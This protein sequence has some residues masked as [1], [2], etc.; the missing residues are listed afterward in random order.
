M[1]FN[2]KQKELFEKVINTKN[3]TLFVIK[4]SKGS[5]FK[6]LNELKHTTFE[7]FINLTKNMNSY[8]VKNV[9]S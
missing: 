4:E 1:K 8:E 2:N 3:N 7:E 5:Y 9:I 6:T